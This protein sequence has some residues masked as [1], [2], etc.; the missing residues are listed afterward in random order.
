MQA[1]G[2]ALGRIGCRW[3]AAE[4][5]SGIATEARVLVVDSYR[6][7]ADALDVG[8]VPVVALDDLDRDLAVDVLVEPSPPLCDGDRRCGR[9]LAGFE[10]ALVQRPGDELA[11]RPD[12]RATTVLVSLG[13]VD[14]AGL[15]ARI[16]HEVAV[17][18]R[19]DRVVHAPG[20]WSR[21]DPSSGVSHL[22][23]DADLMPALVDADVVICA[24]GV[25]MLE[26]MLAGRPTVVVETAR[27]QH[28]AVEGARQAGG[29]VVADPDD[30]SSAADAA[31]SLLADP[32]AAQALAARAVGIVDGRG[33]DRVAAVVVGLLS[34]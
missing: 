33:A 3:R 1:L 2:G 6:V 27:N 15:G 4:L 25:T 18:G 19:S 28:R 26:S 10:Y 32:V 7:R 22:A 5:T 8:P 29:V 13:G 20:P 17:A 12:D 30:P 21:V 16:A 11:R 23:R 34:G 14:A 9:L 24:G 31:M